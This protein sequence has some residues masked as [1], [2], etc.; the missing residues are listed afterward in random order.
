MSKSIII[1]LD[2][3]TYKGQSSYSANTIV[4]NMYPVADRS[5][6]SAFALKPLDGSTV[7]ANIPGLSTTGCRGMYRSTTGSPTDAY[8]GTIYAVFG[9]TL[10]RYTARGTVVTVGT[11]NSGDVSGLCTFAENQAQTDR[12]TYIYVCDRQSIYRFSA[13]ATDAEVALTFR[14]LGNLPHRPDSPTEYAIP[15]YISWDNYRLLMSAKDSNAWFYTDTGTDTFKET[16]VY[17]GESRNDKTQRVTE[18]GGNVWS[19][20]TFSYDI[21]SR[22]GNRLNP[23]SAPKSASGKVGLASP[24]SLAIL[25]DVMLWMGSGDTGTNGVYMASKGGAIKRVSDDGIEEIIKRWQYQS[26]TRGFAWSDK[27]NLFYVLTSEEDNASLGYNITTNKWFSCS[28][29]ED[30]HVNFWDVNFVTYGYNNEIYFGSRTANSICKF[31]S[32]TCIDYAG[33]HVSRLWQSPIFI[34]NLNKFR[35]KKFIVDLEVGLST[36]YTDECKIFIQF[37]WDGGINWRDRI[38]KELGKRGDYRKQV[39]LQGCGQG[40]DLVIRIG[41]SDPVPVVMYQVRLDI[42]E[43]PR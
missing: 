41:T 8:I 19:F 31:D 5:G 10:V 40:R 28:T 17:F 37:S 29:T 6:R 13:K 2:Q 1:P 11:F 27:G 35:L 20:G 9:N 15:A 36:S 25:D 4:Q 32:N 21:F 30:G 3:S 42:E 14:E 39:S 38:D 16:N 22:T 12:D 24:E 18:F 23:Y 43:L 26:Y 33:R 34:A 7:L